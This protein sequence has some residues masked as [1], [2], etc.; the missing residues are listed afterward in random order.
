MARLNNKAT[1]FA[2]YKNNGHDYNFGH[3]V[4]CVKKQ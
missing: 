1:V 3:S 4:R 2:I